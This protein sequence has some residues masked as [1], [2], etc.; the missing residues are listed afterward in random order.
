MDMKLYEELRENDRPTTKFE[1]ALCFEV[2]KFSRFYEE[3]VE[4]LQD[5][6]DRYILYYVIY[7]HFE[8]MINTKQNTYIYMCTWHVIFCHEYLSAHIYKSFALNKLCRC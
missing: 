7:P 8:H 3:T 5:E 1:K 4:A 6:F 2:M